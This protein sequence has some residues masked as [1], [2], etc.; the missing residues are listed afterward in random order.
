MAGIPI[1]G[2]GAVSCAGYGVKAGFDAVAKGH[3]GLSP[4]S[5]F[6]SELKQVPLCGQVLERPEERLR[7]CVPDATSGFAVCAAREALADIPPLQSLRL[8]LVLATTV[9]G[10]TRSEVF[11]RALKK[12]ANHIVNAPEWLAHHEPT[13]TAGTVARHIGA[14]GFHTLS[15]ACST[16]LHAAG[17]AKRL[18]ER[19]AF[20]ACLAVGSDALALLTIR[21]FSSLMLIDPSGCKPFDRRRAGTSL[22]EGAAAILVASEKTAAELGAPS[23][24]YITGWGA[25]ADCHHMTAPHPAGEGAQKAVRAAL[26]DAAVAPGDIG[27]VATHGTATPDNDKSEIAAMK[28]V[29]GDMPP[30]FSLKRTLG[31]TLAASGIL[32]AVFAVCCLRDGIVPPTAGFV[33]QDETIGCAPASYQKKTMRHVLKNSFGFG[34]NNASAVFSLSL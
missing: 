24:A 31:H 33:Q 27:M 25:S 8:G 19:G 13:A 6:D 1:I 3:D 2:L 29:F 5:I 34:G 32:E 9:A 10:I 17:M 7:H 22:G 21:G 20:D 26:A 15:T 14:T 11:Y 28:A 12:D 16:G 23:L 4:L 30:F 18:V